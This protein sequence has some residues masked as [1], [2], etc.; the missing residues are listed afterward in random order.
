MLKAVKVPVQILLASALSFSCRFLCLELNSVSCFCRWLPAGVEEPDGSG[1]GGGG[2]PT[3]TTNATRQHVNQA[4]THRDP[5]SD[6]SMSVQSCF[7]WCLNSLRKSGIM[8]CSV[9]TSVCL[10]NICCVESKEAA[11]WG[12]VSHEPRC[13]MSL[14]IIKTRP[15]ISFCVY[16]NSVHSLRKRSSQE[17]SQSVFH[18]EA[19]PWIPPNSADT[20]NTTGTSSSK[21]TST[22]TALIIILSLL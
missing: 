1:G 4:S 3:I 20:N 16:R 13:F 5:V 17:W 2:Q 22:I 11:K 12:H 14:V 18:V 8:C 7:M 19:P 9:H 21:I 15:V 10:L 6:L